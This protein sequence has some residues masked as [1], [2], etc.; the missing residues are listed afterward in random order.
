D[1]EV[2]CDSG[3]EYPIIIYEIAKK[4]GLKKDKSLPNIIDKAI[5][6]IIKQILNKKN[7]D[8]SLPITIDSETQNLARYYKLDNEL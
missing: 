7:S 3:L 8:F 5:S 2:V 6:H 4:L 1:T